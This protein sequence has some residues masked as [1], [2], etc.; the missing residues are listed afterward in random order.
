[1]K[2]LPSLLIGLA[3]LVLPWTGSAGDEPKIF[4]GT[5]IWEM[6]LL[7][8]DTYAKEKKSLLSGSQLQANIPT[9]GGYD[10]S[11]PGGMFSGRTGF[12]RN[13]GVGI[14]VGGTGTSARNDKA[15]LP[16][17]IQTGALIIKQSGDTIKI[18]N[19]LDNEEVVEEFNPGE[20]AELIQVTETTQAKKVTEVT[21]SENK[22]EIKVTLSS[23]QEGSIKTIRKYEVKNN[24]NELKVT[25][26]VN[27]GG[28]GLPSISAQ[29][30]GLSYSGGIAD[31]NITDSK[32]PNSIM[33]QIFI[34]LDD[35]E[36]KQSDITAK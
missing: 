9:G 3:L 20:S 19:H 11:R 31:G 8:S 6:D 27:Y 29:G 18:I 4:T 36:V 17:S 23:Q 24:G 2:Q 12:N 28:K 13:N 30:Y 16:E 34:K 15:I 21:V 22:L 32:P 25:T 10:M 7:R 1:M 33:K 26:K 35:E 5:G 14:S